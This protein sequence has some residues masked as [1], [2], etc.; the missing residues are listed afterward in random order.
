MRFQECSDEVSAKRDQR[1]GGEMVVVFSESENI[2]EE[3]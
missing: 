3:K 2:E 1:D